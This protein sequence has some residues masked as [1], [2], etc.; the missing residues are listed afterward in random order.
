M[1]IPTAI[2]VVIRPSNLEAGGY[3]VW[4]QDRVIAYFY[5]ASGIPVCFTCMRWIK[6]K[7]NLSA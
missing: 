5:A 7:V 2:S 4:S 1:N 6:D 3:R